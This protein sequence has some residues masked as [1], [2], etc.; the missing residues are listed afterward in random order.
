MI[1]KKLRSEIITLGNESLLD[2]HLIAFLCSRK[3][4]ASV[5]LR[6]YDWAIEQRDEGNCVISGF[7]SQIEKD[8]LHYLLKGKQPIIVVLARG[9]KERIESEFIEPL[10]DGRLLIISPFE[11]NIKRVTKETAFI[12]NKLMVELA[13]SISVGYINPGGLLAELLNGS[14][15]NMQLV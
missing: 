12:R 1:E 13:D 8:I 10:K 3:V 2:L 9:M 5:I 14:E 15:K 6:C 4:P 7:H 11:K